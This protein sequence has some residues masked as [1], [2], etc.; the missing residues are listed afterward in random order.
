MDLRDGN[1]I[2][3]TIDN[4]V[5]NIQILMKTNFA[6]SYTGLNEGIKTKI[7]STAKFDALKGQHNKTFNRTK[8]FEG[9]KEVY[10][11]VKEKL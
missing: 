10:E 2:F 3:T 1:V 11:N 7:M 4:I 8:I 6:I 5:R 9:L